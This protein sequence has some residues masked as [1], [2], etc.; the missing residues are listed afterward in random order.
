MLLP[1][2]GI[3]Q[4]HDTLTNIKVFARKRI[5][6]ISSPAPLQVLNTVDASKTNS[7]S[8]ADALKRFAGVVIKDF[9]GVGGLK[10]VSVRSLG[11]NHTGILYDG[12]ALG[13]AQAGQID[14]GKLSLDN[15]YQIELN[16]SGPSDIL[17]TAKAF[18]YASLLSIKTNSGQLKSDTTNSLS[19][20][21]QSGSFGYFSPSILVHQMLSKRFKIA[22]SSQY[23]HALSD[24][25]YVNYENNTGK[26]RR[27][28]S[29]LSAVRTEA[30]IA[31]QLNDKN[32]FNLKSYYY[33]SKRGLPGAIIFYNPISNQRLNE[34]EFFVQGSWKSKLSSKSDLLINAKYESDKSYYLDPTYPNSYGRLENE[35]YQKEMYLSAVLGYKITND[36]KLSFATDVSNNK[37]TREDVF[38]QNFASPTRNTLLNNIAFQFKKAQYEVTG[39]VLYT[40]LTEKVKVGEPANNV[41]RLSDALAFSIQPFKNLPLRIRAFYKHI[42]RAPTFNDLYY[43]NVGNTKLRP[44]F[45]DQYNIGVTYERLPMY[46]FKKLAVTADAYYNEVTDKILALPRLNLFQWSVQ[47]VGKVKINGIDV[48]VH[49]QLKDWK[50]FKISTDFTY[51]LQKAIDV[52][53]ATSTLFNTQLPY[54]PKH[55]G[56]GTFNISYHDFNFNYNTLFSSLR[57][58][59][60]D[61]V[62][63][64]L[65]Q[66]FVVTDLSLSYLIARQKAY[67]YKIIFEANNVFN[68]QY[69][70]IKYYPIPLFNYRLTINISLKK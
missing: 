29:D 36:F 15:I 10:T 9:G 33:N 11:A 61:Q 18:S 13:N 51:T 69:Q 28:N 64:N 58:K 57:Y 23:Q 50:N 31:F 6:P 8:V 25:L 54:T 38:A 3:A 52:T 43:T 49:A 27:I 62:F 2:F 14:L 12:I 68:T 17:S 55:S 16:N 53:D 41:K 1:L 32:Q 37:L 19:A 5:S 35:F 40:A 67:N 65:L 21:I 7:N 60:G 20:K 63:D 46:I 39:N 45:A 22:I 48:A 70:I 26:N 66:P 24:F 44:E 34:R 42:F 59:N 56:S 4:Q 30:D 47:N